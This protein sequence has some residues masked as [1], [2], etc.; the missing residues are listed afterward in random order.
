VRSLV[1]TAE[2]YGF[3]VAVRSEVGLSDP[4]ELGSTERMMRHHFSYSSGRA[5]EVEK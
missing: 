5:C 1:C 2:E 3:S 4:S